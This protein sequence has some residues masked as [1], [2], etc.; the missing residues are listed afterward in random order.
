MC[1]NARS[2]SIASSALAG[3][4]RSERR[5]PPER[6]ATRAD[7]EADVVRRHGVAPARD[8]DG[9]EAEEDG[10]DRAGGRRDEEQLAR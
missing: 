8:V 7:A 3:A 4:E 9:D 2:S 10:E 6:R 1:R 5:G